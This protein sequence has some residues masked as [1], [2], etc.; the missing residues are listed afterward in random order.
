MLPVWW[1][2]GISGI[3]LSLCTLPL[4]AALVLRRRL[5]VPRGFGLYLVFLLWCVFSATKLDST[6][7]AFSAGYRGS[8]YVGAGLLFLY[9]LNASRDGLPPSGW[10]GSWL[11]SSS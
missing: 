1:A 6:R 9:V 4:F 11:A 7:Q 2:L 8:L 10:S 3:V 5:L